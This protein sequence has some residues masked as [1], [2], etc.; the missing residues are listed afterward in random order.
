M[1][2]NGTLL[3]VEY[4]GRRYPVASLREASEKWVEFCDRT[5][6]G[7]SELPTAHVLDS[8][9]SRIGYIAYN[10]RIF[11]GRPENWT[12]DTRLLYDNAGARFGTG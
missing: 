7:V 12:M 3:F 4:E 1:K 10:G 2:R 11:E 5:G 8:T 6:A 9:G